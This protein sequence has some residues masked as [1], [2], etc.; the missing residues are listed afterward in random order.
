[1]LHADATAP[2]ACRINH[3]EWLIPVWRSE[4]ENAADH[5]VQLDAGSLNQARTLN[6]LPTNSIDTSCLSLKTS[7]DSVINYPMEVPKN[8]RSDSDAYWKEHTTE[9]LEGLGTSYHHHRIEMIRA[10]MRESDHGNL[11]DFG[12]GDGLFL[13]KNGGVGVELA[14]T[15]T[16]KWWPQPQA[17]LQAL[18]LPI[19]SSSLEALRS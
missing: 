15:S 8:R 12:C 13:D 5:Q 1:M 6:I 16:P 2:M 7:L 11:L 17:D 9:Y 14:S 4:M 18:S 10:L 19:L 3:L